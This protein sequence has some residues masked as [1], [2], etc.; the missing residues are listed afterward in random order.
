MVEVI[1]KKKKRKSKHD[2]INKNVPIKEVACFLEGEDG[3][4]EWCSSELRPI[5]REE[6]RRELEY[7]PATLQVKVYIRHAYEC[8]TCKADGEDVIVKSKAPKSVIPKSVASPSA[9]AWLLHQKY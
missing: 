2:H 1:T 8:P 5:G 4:C 3:Q 7:I 9:V 6:V